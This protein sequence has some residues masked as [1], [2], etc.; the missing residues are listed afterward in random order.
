MHYL[1]LKQP[2]V[3]IVYT[4]KYIPLIL[5]HEYFLCS[6]KD[7]AKGK[8]RLVIKRLELLISQESRRRQTGSVLCS[9]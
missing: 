9:S 5:T 4:Q 7:F 3:W 2:F 1:H 6:Y 8:T